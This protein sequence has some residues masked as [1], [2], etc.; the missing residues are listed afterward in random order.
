MFVH[1]QYNKTISVDVSFNHI[2][3]FLFEPD[4][5]R[6]PDIPQTSDNLTLNIE[7]NPLLCDCFAMELRQ[8][9]AGDDSD[10]SVRILNPVSVTCGSASPPHLVNRSLAS[11]K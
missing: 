10:Q 7:G 8:K 9:L 11:I 6:L 3:T 5:G 4:W 2:E 1:C